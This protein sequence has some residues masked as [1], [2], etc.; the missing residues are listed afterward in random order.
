[1]FNRL[2][3]KYARAIS[4]ANERKR[5][6]TLFC[7]RVIMSLFFYLLCVAIIV[8]AVSLSQA[9]E[10]G[11]SDMPFIVFGL[12]LF[13][14]LS[15]GIAAFVLWLVFRTDFRA[16]LN[17]APSKDEMPEVVN[18]RQNT[19]EERKSLI[20]SLWWAI[21]LLVLGIVF[22]IVGITIDTIQNPDV[23]DFGL[24]SGLGTGVMAA[25]LLV[26]FFSFVI[27]KTKQIPQKKTENEVKAIDE[28][29]GRKHRYSLQ[30]DANAYLFGYLFP[31]PKLC[32]QAEELNKKRTTATLLSIII[33]L[34]VGIAID[35]LFF[36]PLIF[37]K[38]LCGYCIPVA[39]TTVIIGAIVVVIKYELKEIALEKQQK[40]EFETYSVYLKNAEIFEKYRAFSKGK[41]RVIVYFI[42]ASIVIAYALAAV[43]PDK[44]WSLVSIV[45]IYVAIGLN[46]FFL[47]SLRKEVKI[48]EDEIDNEGKNIKFRVENKVP[49]QDTATLSSDFSGVFVST[50][51]D[52]AQYRFQSP[53]CVLGLDSDSKKVDSL[54]L[55]VDENNLINTSVS[56]PQNVSDACLYLA[57][58]RTYPEDFV[59]R[60]DFPSRYA[61]DNQ[62][63]ILVFGEPCESV[64]RIFS[65]V[66]VS[67]DDN[68]ALQSV[69]VTEIDLERI[70]DDRNA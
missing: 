50:T 33:S 15:S 12:T 44:M 59:R 61:Y 22:L 31:T 35:V 26:F 42:I 64:C 1:M 32:R 24:W 14:W 70:P 53:Y 52:L 6:Y 45:P 69:F 48:I 28:A 62:N 55:F 2:F 43:F 41:G 25:C 66:Y 5:L 11:E 29:Q 68:G 9:M 67:L 7:A 16:I 60:C 51:N 46:N 4:D 17:R 10:S 54:S 19:V 21:A 38:N 49:S 23:D 57:D 39:M 3:Q 65:N 34:I 58:D 27:F 40:K 13:L 63:K 8:E 20:K 47:S 37:G 18:Y 30:E 56:M 36:T